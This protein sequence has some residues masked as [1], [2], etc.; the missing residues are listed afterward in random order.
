MWS[1]SL[2]EGYQFREI[3]ITPE[4]VW[5][6]FMWLNLGTEAL[7]ATGERYKTDI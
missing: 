6:M 2:L 5:E 7:K 1:P 4:K 3:Q